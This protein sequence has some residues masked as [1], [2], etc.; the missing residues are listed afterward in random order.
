MI[1]G[2]VSGSRAVCGLSMYFLSASSSSSRILFPL[3]LSLFLSSVL[4]R[5]ALSSSSIVCLAVVVDGSLLVL[6]S[7][8]L[9]I[10]IDGIHGVSNVSWSLSIRFLLFA[11]SGGAVSSTSEHDVAEFDTPS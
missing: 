1:F 2:E 6:V 5:N 3:I 7:S 11:V 8:G 9:V 10:M 4:F